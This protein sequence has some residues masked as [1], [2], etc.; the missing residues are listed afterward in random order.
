MSRSWS[1]SFKKFEK[2]SLLFEK[3]QK[4][5]KDFGKT[6]K[7]VRIIEQ[8]QKKSKL[9]INS[10]QCQDHCI[11]CIFIGI[12]I[13]KKMFG[14]FSP[15]DVFYRTF[16]TFGRFSSDVIHLRTFFIGRFHL[17][18]FLSDVFHLRTFSIAPQLIILT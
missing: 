13:I 7:N 12:F 17:G 18:R 2:M 14:P 15:S 1:R 11:F 4:D 6:R 8:T 10:K 9:L 5:I 16:L 3:N